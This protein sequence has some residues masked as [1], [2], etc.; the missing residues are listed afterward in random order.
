MTRLQNLVALSSAVQCCHDDALQS[1][2]HETATSLKTMGIVVA[3]HIARH[4]QSRSVTGAGIV[5]EG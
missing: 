3:R 1:G 5:G 2:D 4:V